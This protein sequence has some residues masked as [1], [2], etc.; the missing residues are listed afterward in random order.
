MEIANNLVIWTTPPS[1]AELDVALDFVKPRIITLVC[2]HPF[3][4]SVDG[5]LT[6]LTGLL[7][8]AITRAAGKVT[9]VELAAA[10]SERVITVELGLNWLVSSGKIILVHQ[11]DDQLWVA[12]GKTV[13]DLGGAARLRVEIQALLEETAAY[14]VFFQQADKKTL[15]P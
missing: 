11:E 4:K 6:R 13:N 9:Y 3:Q 15:F 14:R 5:Y 8:Y 12:P 7:K 10:T 2:T 1:P